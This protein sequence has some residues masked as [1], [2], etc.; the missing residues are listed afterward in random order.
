M[1]GTAIILIA[2]DT[3]AQRAADGSDR[4]ACTGSTEE[5]PDDSTRAGAERCAGEGAFHGVVAARRSKHECRHARDKACTRDDQPIAMTSGGHIA[6]LSGREVKV[7]RG[8]CLYALTSG[9]VATHYA[10]SLA[11]CWLDNKL[12]A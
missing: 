4:R 6:C 9:Q 2:D 8:Q 7:D 3:S 10:D 1:C 11:N 12:H 5:A